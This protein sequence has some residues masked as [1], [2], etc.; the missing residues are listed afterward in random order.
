MSAPLWALCKFYKQ[1]LACVKTNVIQ[2]VT[3]GAAGAGHGPCSRRCLCL[4]EGRGEMGR[5]QAA[6]LPFSR[7]A[8]MCNLLLSKVQCVRFHL[9]YD[10]RSERSSKASNLAGSGKH[11]ARHAVSRDLWRANKVRPPLL[12]SKGRSDNEGPSFKND[13]HQNTCAQFLHEP[14]QTTKTLKLR[15]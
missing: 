3:V 4:A 15:N 8:K 11:R 9:I 5:K 14:L 2:A 10:F 13:S 12:E 1:R 6:H 7:N